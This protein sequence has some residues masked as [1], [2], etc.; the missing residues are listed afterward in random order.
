MLKPKNI[1]IKKITEPDCLENEN[2]KNR[3]SR[4]SLKIPR[5]QP[6]QSNN[7]SPINIMKEDT[8]F[9]DSESDHGNFI[10]YINGYLNQLDSDKGETKSRNT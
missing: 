2:K 4:K 6:S 7:P 9:N 5:R 1:S 10:K 8:N 3:N